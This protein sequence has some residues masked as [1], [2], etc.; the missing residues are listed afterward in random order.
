MNKL[1]YSEKLLDPRWQR[2]RLEIY[3]RDNFACT[4]CGDTQTT[5]AVHHLYYKGEPWEAPD[6]ALKTVCQDCHEIIEDVKDYNIPIFKH[7][8]KNG[9]KI[10]YSIYKTVIILY[11]KDGSGPVEAK[12]ALPLSGLHE[13]SAFVSANSKM[14]EL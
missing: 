1:T 4:K 9:Y 12:F 7:T 5:L 8:G 3:G 11:E 6:D 14:F 10:F 13:L 2:R